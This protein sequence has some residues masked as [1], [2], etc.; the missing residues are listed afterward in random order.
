MCERLG[1]SVHRRS[2]V[3]GDWWWLPTTGNVIMDSVVVPASFEAIPTRWGGRPRLHGE[4]SRAR[5]PRRRCGDL[6]RRDPGPLAGLAALIIDG[7]D[8]M[9]AR[10]L[11]VKETIPQF[12]GARPRR[13]RRLHHLCLRP[14]G[15]ALDRKFL[16]RGELGD[17]A[18]RVAAARLHLP[19]LPGRREDRGPLLP[20]LPELLERHRYY[21]FVMPTEASTP[22]RSSSCLCSLL[23]FVPVSSTSTPPAPGWHAAP[24]CSSRG[25]G[26]SATP[27]Y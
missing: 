23:V 19:V 15:V 3:T 7:S 10:R 1:H 24:T 12:D 17:R 25:V 18:G 20:R 11:R 8:G 22:W 14:G 27:S 21:A 6:R 4:R 13:H 9:L 5:V 26:S 16:A 2:W